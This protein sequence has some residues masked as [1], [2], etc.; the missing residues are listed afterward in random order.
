MRLIHAAPAGLL[1]LLL[2]ACGGSTGGATAAPVDGAAET[3]EAAAT[4]AADPVPTTAAGGGNIGGGWAT[5]PCDLLTQT[6]VEQAAGAAGMAPTPIP[7]D[8]TSG[9][10]GYRSADYKSEIVLSVWGGDQ[11][12]SMFTTLNTLLAANADGIEG[13]DGLGGDAIYSA[14]DGTLVVSKNGTAVQVAVR[15][16]DRD[17]AAIK[18]IAL[19]LG[20]QVADKL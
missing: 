5:K 9:L 19:D 12:V 7:M 20:R 15:I 4:D 2:A 14:A 17:P 3:A 18:A 6:D 8:A 1:V 11:A 16:Q 13:V 10:C